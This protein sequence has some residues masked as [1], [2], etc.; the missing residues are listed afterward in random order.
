MVDV[1][2]KIPK[3]TE[4]TR[5]P[6]S[7]QQVT[8][9]SGSAL[10]RSRAGTCRRTRWTRLL[11]W[12]ER[13]SCTTHRSCRGWDCRVLRKTQ[14]GK[15]TVSKRP[16]QLFF[17]GGFLPPESFHFAAPVSVRLQVSPAKPSVQMQMNGSS[18]IPVTHVPP[19]WQT[20]TW[21]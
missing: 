1:K 16:M 11:A 21:Q 9:W 3:A 2:I 17:L 13:Q 19:L 15:Q 10:P 7:L 8:Y 4:A 18:P 12:S 5:T 20:F 6:E 14:E